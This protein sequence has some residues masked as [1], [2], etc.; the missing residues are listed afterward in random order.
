MSELPTNLRDMLIQ[1][2]HGNVIESINFFKDK[3]QFFNGAIL[4]ELLP[5]NLMSGELLY[6]QND[7]AENIYFIMNGKFTLVV[8]LNEYIKNEDLFEQKNPKNKNKKNKDQ[9]YSE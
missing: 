4:Y 3:S 5:I 9:G 7:V 1:K 8:D 2:T 6:Q